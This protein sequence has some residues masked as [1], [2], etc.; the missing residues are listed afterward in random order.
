MNYL[1]V[2]EFFLDQGKRLFSHLPG[3]V[4]EEDL[5]KIEENIE[6]DFLNFLSK[7]IND[8]V[9]YG[10]DIN[11]MD[12]DKD[13]YWVIDPISGTNQL[14]AGTAEY[15]LCVAEV[16][17]SEIIYALVVAPAY[18]EFFEAKKGQGVFHNDLPLKKLKPIGDIILNMD[19][20]SNQVEL[21]KQVWQ[22]SVSL[23]PF[24]LNQSSALSYCR[25]AQGR[26]RRIVSISKDSFPYFAGT[27]ILNESG[28]LSTNKE[29]NINISP[30]D[31]VF[32]G[33]ADEVIYADTMRLLN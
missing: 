13:T 10:E 33:A 9:I 29:G 21:Q 32:I 23:Y 12:P 28:G 5:K 22:A 14:Y 26:Y 15:A 16:K 7:E 4:T 17:N 25:V 6:S 11:N 30:R 31:R 1:A 27:F 18:N 2:R 8:P 24:V 20:S 19:P 3:D